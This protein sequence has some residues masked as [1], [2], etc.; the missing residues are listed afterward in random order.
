[1]GKIPFDELFFSRTKDFLDIF[2]P[3]QADRSM[4]TVKA[5]RFSLT[6][7]YQYVTIV[8]EIPAMKF[9][10]TDCT[11]Q[12]MLNYSE[13]LQNIKKYVPNSVNQRIAAIKSYLRYVSDGNIALIQIYLCVK[14]V[15]LLKAPKV[16]RPII[17]KAE[18]GIFLDC[19]A[20]TRIGNRDRVMLI[21]LYDS[22]IRLS[23][24][25]AIK[26]GDMNQSGDGL[27]VIIHGKGNKE[28]E[29]VLNPK[30]SGHIRSYINAYHA[31]VTDPGRPLFYT[32][33]HGILHRMSPRNVE[34]IVKK[35]GDIVRM[36]H[37]D[38]PDSVYPHMVRR[39]RA[40]GLYRDSV[41]LEIISRILGHAY[42]ET[43]R[44]YAIPSAEQ[45]RDV[46]EKNCDNE[47]E[48]TALWRG[49]EEELMHM[50]GLG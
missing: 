26:L 33:S 47:P 29:V 36:E 35:Y 40:S 48:E 37:P 34:R 12:F 20:D 2:L 18:L 10:F 16:R 13:Y 21:L 5:Y 3:R 31:G 28:R 46:M 9:R 38:M 50:F 32:V 41:P 30:V 15:P 14:K 11:Y 8:T 19:P 17:E 42:T 44:L 27:S 7:F 45:L 22:A 6:A 23:E 24:L 49:K 25:L 1:M 39:T 43:T 4:Q